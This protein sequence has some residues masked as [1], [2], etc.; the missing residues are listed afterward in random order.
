MSLT[1]LEHPRAKVASAGRRIRADAPAKINLTL[2]VL[3]CRDDGFHELRSLVIGVDLADRV[4][5][6]TSTVPGISLHCDDPALNN[7]DNV[8]VL[9]ARSLAKYCDRE[10]ALRI[11]LQK[12]IPVGGGLGGGSSDAA[13]TLRLCDFLWETGLDTTELAAIGAEL[14]SDVPLFFSLPSAVIEGRGEL[15]S[16]VQLRWSGWV[17][18]LCPPIPVSTA[19]VYRAFRPDDS[20]GF[21]SGT[22]RDIL[23]AASAAELSELLSNHLET[24]VFRVCPTVYSLREALTSLDL[25]SVHVTGSGSALY[26]LFDDPEPALRAANKIQERWSH[27]TTVVAAAPVGQGP[28]FYEEC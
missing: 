7:G 26:C 16:P 19:E 22:D 9:A 18:L 2:E 17:L 25:T 21:P 27:V 14:G 8:A 15:V 13:T 3:G 28:I 12:H 10:P 1:T 11:D 23:H 5:C 4:R 24:A 20:D 6:R